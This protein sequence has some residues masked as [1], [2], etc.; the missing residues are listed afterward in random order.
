MSVSVSPV[1]PA[2]V[3]QAALDPWRSSLPVPMSHYTTPVIPQLQADTFVPRLEEG[4]LERI[5]RQQYSGVDFRIPKEGI[6]NE[7]L[8][9]P[10]WVVEK[11]RQNTQSPIP[12]AKPA[13]KPSTSTA[14]AAT[15]TASA[16][17]NAGKK[18]AKSGGKWGWIL[19]GVVALA[20]AAGG[21]KMYS[22][23]Q[24]EQKL[25]LSA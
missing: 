6:P 11:A 3:P 22:D 24:Q 8:P 19:G 4:S 9:V 14:S 10:M 18:A 16:T 25:N 1:K 15:S 13:V 17:A 2:A 7:K 12:P 20:G 5:I 21:Y 23:K